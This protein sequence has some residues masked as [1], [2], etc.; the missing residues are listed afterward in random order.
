MWLVKKPMPNLSLSLF[1]NQQLFSFVWQRI[2]HQI[3]GPLA[4]F[5]L[6]PEAQA[7]RLQPA[8]DDSSFYG[9]RNTDNLRNRVFLNFQFPK[10]IRSL[11]AEDNL[12]PILG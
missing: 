3:F 6:L 9:K 7:L 10:P 5:D 2:F 8:F 12:G 4:T 1:I 11:I